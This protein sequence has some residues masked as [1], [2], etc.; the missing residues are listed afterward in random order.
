M[1]TKL[2]TLLLFILQFATA[3]EK[4][5]VKDFFWGKNDAFQK[6]NAIPDKWKNESAV[7][8]H[9]YEY[10]DYHK[11]G[12]NVTYTSGIRKRIKLLFDSKINTQ[13]RKVKLQ[14]ASL[15]II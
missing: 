12:V 4:N 11:F 14:W 10:Y 1:K 6:A 8:L 2:L 13:F 5:E 3:Q 15:Q 7:I 9:K